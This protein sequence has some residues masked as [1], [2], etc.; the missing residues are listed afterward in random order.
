VSQ[1]RQPPSAI[2]ISGISHIAENRRERRT[3]ACETG[4]GVAASLTG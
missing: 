4:G 3:A 2:A 1:A